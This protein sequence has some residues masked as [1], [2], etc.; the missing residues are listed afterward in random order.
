MEKQ[1][2]LVSIIVITYNSSKYVLDTLESAKKQTYKN[3]ELIVTDDGSTDETIKICKEW[4]KDNKQ[5]F[6]RTEL[7]EVE[8]NTGI[9][10]NCNRG[11]NAAKGEWIKIIAGDDILHERCVES[12]IEFLRQKGF[13][14]IMVVSNMIQFIHGDNFREGKLIVPKLLFLFQ[15]EV[16]ARVQNKYAIKYYLGNTPTLFIPRS[17]LIKVPFDESI[18]YQEDRPFAVNAT[19]E[20]Y[21]FRYNNDTTA[22]Y[23]ISENSVFTSKSKRVIFNDFYKK[24]RV[25]VLKYIYPNI[26][27]YEKVFYEIEFYRQLLFDSLKLNKNNKICK[28]IYSTSVRITPLFYLKKYELIKVAKKSLAKRKKEFK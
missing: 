28:F 23:R 16:D 5:N 21:T 13:P 4:L 11:V 3:I 6:L 9:P 1:Y 12:N 24:R 19:K 26:P 17:I 14:E 18:P 15:E 8:N 10:A 2:P 20:G 25:F 22:Y 7:L 27:F